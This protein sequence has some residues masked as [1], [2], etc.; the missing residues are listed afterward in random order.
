[1]ATTAEQKI[2]I[3]LPQ[4]LHLV[5]WAILGVGALLLLIGFGTDSIGLL[6][7]A[8]FLGI[9]ARIVQAE[10]H[11]RSASKLKLQVPG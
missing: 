10:H 3:K 9:V 1:M 7:A 4:D 5:H 2:E 11:V 6:I 8:C